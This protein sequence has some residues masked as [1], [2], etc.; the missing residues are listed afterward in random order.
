MAAWDIF[1]TVVDN[2]GDAGIT[3]R[4]A[5]QLVAEH[6]QQVRLWIDDL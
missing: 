5:H 6:G 3:W 2:Y 1:C 4:L